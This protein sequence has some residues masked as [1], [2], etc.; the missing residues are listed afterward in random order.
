MRNHLENSVR[1][2]MEILQQIE[3]DYNQAFKNKNELVIL[4]LRQL[5]T[6][7]TNAEIAKNREKLTEEEVI[8]LLRTEVKKRKEAAQLY[9]KGDRQELADKERQEIEL[10]SKYL[11]AQLDEEAIKQKI[12]EII[13]KLGA[14]GPQDIGKVMGAVMKELGGQADGNTVSSLVK[15]ELTQKK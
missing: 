4:V 3:E 11:P 6:A 9:T 1:L 10:I 2:K 13:Q 7:L 12:I 14:A 5:K 8:K 15:Q